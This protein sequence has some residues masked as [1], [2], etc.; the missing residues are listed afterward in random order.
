MSPLGSVTPLHPSALSRLDAPLPKI[1]LPQGTAGNVGRNEGFGN[2]LDGLVATV[3]AKQSV[4]QATT[5]RCC[6]AI[7]ISY[8]KASSRCR[9]PPSLFQ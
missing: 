5:R 1:G 4:A 3:D 8:I 9:R 7:Q 6:S 2:M